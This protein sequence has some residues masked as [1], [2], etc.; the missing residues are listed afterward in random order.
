MIN[1]YLREWG[2]SLRTLYERNKEVNEQARPMFE[3]AIE[4]DPSY[5]G[6]YAGLGWSYFLDWFYQ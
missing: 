2:S 1:Y 3:K 5:A 4:L 6:A